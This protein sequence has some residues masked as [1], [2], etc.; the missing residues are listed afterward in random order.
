M[1][2]GNVGAI[3]AVKNMGLMVITIINFWT[4]SAA[5]EHSANFF[6]ELI[7]RSSSGFCFYGSIQQ[8]WNYSRL[9]G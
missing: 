1:R 2:E 5:A 4:I 6:K 9:P 8:P 3:K 7:N